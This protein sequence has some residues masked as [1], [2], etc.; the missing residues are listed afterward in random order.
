MAT[1]RTL[2]PA[3]FPGARGRSTRPPG[4]NSFDS[5]VVIAVPEG[6]QHARLQGSVGLHS[7][8][9]TSTARYS[10]R[11]PWPHTIQESRS[12]REVDFGPNFSPGHF[13]RGCFLT[14]LWP[15]PE[16]ESLSV[17]A[18]RFDAPSPRQCARALCESIWLD[19]DCLSRLCVHDHSAAPFFVLAEVPLPSVRVHQPAPGPRRTVYRLPFPRQVANGPGNKHRRECRGGSLASGQPQPEP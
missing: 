18:I 15:G 19:D 7:L 5:R 1:V 14:H 6:D 2:W 17:R 4:M 12:A 10:N 3:I 8:A 13:R 9:R 16:G 11:R